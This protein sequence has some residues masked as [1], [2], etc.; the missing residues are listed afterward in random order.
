MRMKVL[1]VS[2]KAQLLGYSK[3]FNAADAMGLG[4]LYVAA[5]ARAAGHDVRVR[6]CSDAEAARLVK[7]LA[8]QVVGLTAMSATYPAALAVA[9]SVKSVAPETVTVMGG[10]HVTFTTADTLREGC[11]DYVVRGE[12]EDAFPRLLQC[13]AGG[14]TDPSIP[15]VCFLRDGSVENEHSLAEV[16]E[17]DNLPIPDQRLLESP[18]RVLV[19]GSRGCPHDCT[20]CSVPRFCRRKWRKRSVA[21]IL[22]ELEEIAR[23]RRLRRVEFRDDNLLVDPRW[24]EELCQGILQRGF[25]F[26]WHCLGRTDTVARHPELLQ[27]MKSSGCRIVGLGLESGLQEII[28]HYEKGTSV[29]QARE[30]SARLRQHSILQ[31]WYAMIGSGDH[32][33]TLEQVRRN[34]QHL[35]AFPFDLL[36]L[37]LLTPFPGTRLY[38]ELQ[39][40]GRLLHRRW[41]LYDGMHCV[42]RPLG[43]SAEQLEGEL[44]RS[45]KKIF[46]GSGARRVLHTLYSARKFIFNTI[47][48]LKLLRVLFESLVLR[49]DMF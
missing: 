44:L 6:L 7:E 29:E 49:R 22:D 28:D 2:P 12:G 37:S 45:Y 46:I 42:Y 11:I 41:E 30:V 34:V 17:L 35:A 26:D 47:D 18:G 23:T 40:E 14:D 32:N 21:A 5:A 19:I 20:F 1:L 48:P 31:V 10:H 3:L 43:M 36:Q 8:P 13:L 24:A 16:S 33:D 38:G 15:G 25:R 39:R 4:I 9:R 27:L